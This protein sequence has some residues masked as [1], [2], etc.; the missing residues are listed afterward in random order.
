LCLETV[1]RNTIDRDVENNS[2]I[3]A[4]AS[5]LRSILL[6][7]GDTANVTTTVSNGSHTRECELELRNHVTRR[8]KADLFIYDA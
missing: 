3:T 5:S 8:M 2:E 1:S 4:L 7:H 6:Q